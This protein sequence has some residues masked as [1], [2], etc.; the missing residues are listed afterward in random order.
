MQLAITTTHQPA[1][2]LGFLLHKHPDRFQTF[3]LAFGRA[4]V[5]YPE[6]GD[7]RCTAVLMLDIDP[8]GLTRRD[9]GPAAHYVNDR[10]Y[11]AS[12]Y[13]SVAISRV[14]GTALARRCESRPELVET[15]IPL[16]ARLSVVPSRGGEEQLQRLFEPLGYQ[17][18]VNGHLLDEAF[19]DW[20]P[21]PYFTV[22]LAGDVRLS[23]LLT[24]LYVLV[25]VLDE[26]K[27]YFV[28]DAEVEKLL[29]QGEPWLS[30][31]PER[32]AIIRGYLKRRGDLVRDA[33]ERLADEPAGDELEEPDPAPERLHDLRLEATVAVLRERGV[34][35]VVDLGCGEGRLLQLLLREPQFERIVGMDVSHVALERARRRLR[36]DELP[37]AIAGKVSLL[38]G[39]LTYRDQRLAGFDAATVVEVVEHMEPYRLDAFEQVIFGHARPGLVVLTTPNREYN[40]RFSGIEPGALRH[41]DHRFEWDRTEFVAWT[42]SI[43]GR[44]GYSV[45]IEPVGEVDPEVGPPSQLAVFEREVGNSV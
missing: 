39:S 7:E 23:D 10:P 13:L 28:G 31:H 33:L 9:A 16:E 14:Y 11:V 27:H 25:P 29:R 22:T 15:A 44:F 43:A 5:F 38:H 32:E 19:P 34:K 6:A 8:V 40:V 24:H 3:D 41:P 26:S 18:D 36:L 20:G 12:S 2:D 35:S 4:H 30:S 21:S 42:D 37:S 45:R 17:V 1:T